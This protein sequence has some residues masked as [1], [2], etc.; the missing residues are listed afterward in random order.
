MVGKR[1]RTS[2]SVQPVDARLIDRFLAFRATK[3]GRRSIIEYGQDLEA[4]AAFLAESKVLVTNATSEDIAAWFTAN[5]RDPQDPIDERPWS[6]SSAHR[7]RSALSQFYKW[8]HRTELIGRNPLDS[9]ELRR[10]DRKA[11]VIVERALLDRLLAYVESRIPAADDR[12]AP[13]FILDSAIFTIMDALAL[14]VSEV[15]GL[16]LSDFR[17][18]RGEVMPLVRKK[19]NKPKPYPFTGRVLDVYRRWL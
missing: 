7:R 9:V 13:L 8:A 11:P 17:M 18:S 16:R 15:S 3:L 14:R 1:G 4:F 10:K 19:G 12:H 2:T 6:V 5:T